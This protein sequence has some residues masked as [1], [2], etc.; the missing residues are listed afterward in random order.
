MRGEGG[1]EALHNSDITAASAVLLKLL[2]SWP[3]SLRRA[4][5]RLSGVGGDK[6]RGSSV[7]GAGVN[8]AAIQAACQLHSLLELRQWPAVVLRCAASGYTHW[9]SHGLNLLLHLYLGG[10]GNS[11]H[12]NLLGRGSSSCALGDRDNS[13]S[14][15]GD[16]EGACVW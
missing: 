4:A 1:R 16:C 8:S 10:L 3:R 7:S 12:L 15:L 11:N 5:C 14:I 9:D 13:L 2:K 6:L